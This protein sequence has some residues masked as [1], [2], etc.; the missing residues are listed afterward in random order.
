MAQSGSAVNFVVIFL[1]KGTIADATGNAMRKAINQPFIQ[2]KKK[3]SAN[4]LSIAIM[5][6]DIKKLIQIETIKLVSRLAYFVL[7][8]TDQL[9]AMSIN[10]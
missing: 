2:T 7:T 8:L 5:T 3:S 9:V 4:P 1:A 6:N 10:T